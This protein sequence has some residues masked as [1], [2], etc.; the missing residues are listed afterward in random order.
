[1]LDNLFSALKVDLFLILGAEVHSAWFK[2]LNV[3][4]QSYPT[5]KIQV[6][7]LGDGSPKQ[8]HKKYKVE[9]KNVR[10]MTLLKLKIYVL[11][12]KTKKQKQPQNKQTKKNTSLRT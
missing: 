3:K 11:A 12:K 7:I 6:T 4:R 9:R 5:L 8:R 10:P 2:V 1:M